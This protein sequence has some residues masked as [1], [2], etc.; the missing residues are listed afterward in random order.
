MLS[1]PPATAASTSPSR[2]YC[3]ALTIACKPLPQRRLSV[4]APV[5]TGR[6]PLTHATR[7][8]YM[9]FASVWITLPKTHCP[10]SFGSTLARAS[11]SLTTRAASSVG[12]MSLRLPP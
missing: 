11:A 4:S 2:M 3:D 10:M 5:S 6:P 9:S 12:A 7:D 8:R 1:A